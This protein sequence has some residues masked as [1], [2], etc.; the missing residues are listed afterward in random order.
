MVQ[1]PPFVLVG[2]YREW[3]WSAGSDC[4]A[5]LPGRQDQLSCS[6]LRVRV[7]QTKATPPT[8]VRAHAQAASAAA[9]NI[10]KHPLRKILA[11]PL[12]VALYKS[13]GE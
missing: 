12:I 2:V 9:E 1:T 4:V 3:Q 10:F 11:T 6:A 7:R 13:L 5:L 8:H